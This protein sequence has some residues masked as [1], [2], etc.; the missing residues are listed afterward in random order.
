MNRE[1]KQAMMVVKKEKKKWLPVEQN[2]MELSLVFNAT[3]E[4]QEKGV[5]RR[6]LGN[7]RYIQVSKDIQGE[8][9]KPEDLLTFL[10]CFL[11]LKHSGK[12]GRSFET[13]YNQFF[14]LFGEE[15]GGGWGYK[16][17]KQSLERLQTNNIT[18]NFWF[19]TISGKRI[20]LQKFHFLETVGE[21]EEQSLRVR[22]SEDI[23]K[24]M[25]MGYLRWLEEN[26][27][28]EILH[29]KKFARVLALFLLKR[30]NNGPGVKFSL[31]KILDILG[32]KEK[33]EKLPGHRFNFYVKRT[34]IPAVEKASKTIRYGSKYDPKEK[35][36]YIWKERKSLVA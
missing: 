23:V 16:R 3:K 18:T 25:E 1:E 20:T 9:I 32:V 11:L 36:F 31:N 24:S 7:E 13:S 35:M 14:T 4:E 33:Y 5:V 21:G 29:L 6:K 30:T 22:L 17:L 34:I 10:G 15:R 19:D 26:E 2:S 28:K 12:K 8:L 27:L